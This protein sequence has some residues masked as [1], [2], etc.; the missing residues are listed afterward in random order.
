MKQSTARWLYAIEAAFISN[1]AG[2]V[3]SGATTMGFAPDK[4]NLSSISG[5][6][7]LLALMAINFIASGILGVMI[8]LK[9]NPVP[10]AGDTVFFTKGQTAPGDSAQ[11]SEKK[12]EKSNS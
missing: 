8:Y 4:F 6:L 2:T 3:V 5:V 10:P 9:Q 1:G 7:H 12:D 11:T